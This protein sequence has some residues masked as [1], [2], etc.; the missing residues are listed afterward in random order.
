MSSNASKSAE[1]PTLVVTSGE[2]AGIGPDICLALAG[3]DLPVR[4]RVLGDR[5][6]LHSRA[7]LLGIDIS[8]LDIEHVPLR[9]PCVAG[10]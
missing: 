1:R 5:S 3:A 9:A 10:S 4:I 7:A 6:L 2:P 8:G